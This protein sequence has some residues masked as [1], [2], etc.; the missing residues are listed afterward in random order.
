MDKVKFIFKPYISILFLRDIKAGLVLFILS[1]LLPSVGI[2]GIVAILS[3]ILFAEFINVRDEY[4]KYGFYLYNSLLVGMGVG[5]FFDV[6]IITILLTIMLSILTFLVSFSINRV[7]VKYSLPLLSLPFAVVSMVFYLASLKYTGLLSNILYRKAIFDMNLPFDAFFKSMGT[8]FFLPFSFAG[9]VISLLILIYSRILFLLAFVGFWI[10]VWFHSFFVPFSQALNSP[11]NFNYI[12]IAM[13]LGGVFLIPNIKNFLLAFLAVFL[14]IVLI[15]AMEVFFNIYALPVYTLPFNFTTLLFIMILYSMGYLFFNYNI[16]D[17]PEK[18]L[19]AFLSNFYRFGG[20]DIKINLPFTGEWCVY[21][22][23]DG[24]W[25]HKGKWKYA[26]D[27]VIKKNGKTYAN[28]GLF[29]E[30]YYAFGKPVV[31]PVNGYVIAKRDDLQDN[32]I[33]N[34]DR[35]NNWG[36][37]IIIKSDYGYFVE[38]SHL[39]QNSINVK[40]GDYVKVGDI[41]AKCGNSGYS[42][43]PHIHIQV[44][45]YGILGS[46]TIPFK[47]IDYIKENKLYF[48]SLPKKD[49]IIESTAIDKAMKLRLT[50]ILDDKFTYEVIEKNKKSSLELV[51]KMN[52]KGEFYFFD[53]ENKLY[54]YADEKLFYF[55]EYE[56]KESILKEIF[57]LA[58]KIPLINKK[59]EY[60]DVLPPQFIYGLFKKVII[61]LLLPFNFKL[62]DKKVFYEKEML[63]IKSKFGEIVFSF[64]EKGFDKIKTDNFEIRRINEK[65]NFNN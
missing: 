29:L 55:Y 30:D 23:F 16:K 10:G 14:S 24:E 38:I 57:K 53:G 32:F 1:F 41:I 43:E 17:T 11:Y 62:F 7:F 18:S 65:D 6:T 52:E 60:Y 20:N 3:T 31:A 49:E 51:V 27:F 28:D 61:E 47:F 5:Y 50:F 9:F 54:F 40:V 48:Y 2:L 39:M 8:I 64:Y 26:Y 37:Y 63:K 19:I 4:L 33:G 59:V 46:E 21:Q 36:N 56:G 45:K 34:V 42:P 25:T 22:A 13:A 44:Q 35:N 58:P 12:L 15:D